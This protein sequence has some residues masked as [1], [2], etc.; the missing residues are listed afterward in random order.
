LKE[1]ALVSVIALEDLLRKTNI[2]V[3]ST[4]EPFFFYLVACLIYIVLALISSVGLGGIDRWTRR[5]EVR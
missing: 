4:K 1:T 3:G 2:A 5:G